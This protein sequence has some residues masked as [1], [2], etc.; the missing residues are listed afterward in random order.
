M[1]RRVIVMA[2][3]VFMTFVGSGSVRVER[4]ERQEVS[5]QAHIAWVADALKRMQTVKVGMTRDDL[6]KVFGEEGGISTALQRT[7]A[8]LDCPYF[9]VD[10]EFEA[11]GRPARDSE[12]RVTLVEGRQDVIVKISRPYLEMRG[13]N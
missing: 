6:L 11:V 5:R 10:V 8:S 4:P 12:G 9:Q 1:I 13:P 7:F 2:M 3:L